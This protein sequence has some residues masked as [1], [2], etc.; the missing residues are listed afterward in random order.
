[1]NV[2]FAVMVQAVIEK[3]GQRMAFY[4]NLDEKVARLGR[5]LVRRTKGVCKSARLSRIIREEERKQDEIFRQMGEYYYQMHGS[6]AEGQLKVW[7]DAVWNN[8]MMV[9]QY[10]GQKRLV[11]GATYCPNCGREV[12]QHS[13]YCNHCGAR[14]MATPEIQ[15]EAIAPFAAKVCQI[16]GAAVGEHDIFCPN[17]G[18]RLPEKKTL[19]DFVKIKV[20]ARRV[21]AAQ[22]EKER[23]K[24][25]QEFREEKIVEGEAVEVVAA[26]PEKKPETSTETVNVETAAAENKTAEAVVTGTAAAEGSSTGPVGEIPK[27]EDT[28]EKRICPDCGNAIEPGQN[29]CPKCGLKIEKGTQPM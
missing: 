16:C 27:V 2:R 17:C 6:E 1:M 3:E 26:M 12:P 18:G 23:I 28:S 29:F 4:D 9:I 13:K 19:R 25:E 24:E 10:Q 7:C 15:T 14:M 20:V 5:E 8:K 11:K 21:K 22:D